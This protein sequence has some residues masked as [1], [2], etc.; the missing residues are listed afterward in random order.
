ME[1][2]YACKIHEIIYTYKPIK[3][4]EIKHTKLMTVVFSQV[5]RE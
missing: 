1:R 5:E 2:A 4:T 3:E